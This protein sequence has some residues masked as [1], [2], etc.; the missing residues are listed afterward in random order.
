MKRVCVFCGSSSGANPAFA[1]AA[2]RLGALLAA[3][4]MGLV[5]GGGEVGLMGEV[6]RACLGAGGEGHGVIPH[7]LA[8]L[9]LAF[10]GI[11]RLH[12]V[13]TMHERKALM[14]ELA[15]GFV[16]LPGGLGT[17]DELFDA[18]TS[19]Q[20]GLH[21]KPC[22]LLNVA[23][24]FDALL[25]FLDRAVADGFVLA[26]HRASLLADES[27]ERLLARMEGERPPLPD[28][29]AWAKR[30]AGEPPRR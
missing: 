17:L 18:A 20:L 3:R 13:E 9:E 19:A 23:G 24:Y 10:E 21:E 7:R 25:A 27:P 26:E 22:G 15:D 8:E 16:A 2:S 6:A 1:E 29:I 28:K 30:L 14:A 4:G 11:T 5:Y 12:V